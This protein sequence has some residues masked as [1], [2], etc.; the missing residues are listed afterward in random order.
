MPRQRNCTRAA[1]DYHDHIL[2]RLA[3]YSHYIDQSPPYIP[4]LLLRHI[5]CRCAGL[6]ARV[7]GVSHGHPNQFWRRLSR[8]PSPTQRASIQGHHWADLRLR[9]SLTSSIRSISGENVVTA[10]LSLRSESLDRAI[11]QA[12]S[13]WY[14]HLGT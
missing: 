12:E 7:K 9:L 11:V 5:V 1:D 14:N 2:D 6:K 3:C 10:S 13:P 8:Q 4:V